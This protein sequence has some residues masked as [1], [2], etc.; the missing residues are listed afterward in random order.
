MITGL[1]ILII[2]DTERSD[3]GVSSS[4]L[5]FVPVVA[6]CNTSI[7]IGTCLTSRALW[8]R[9]HA[10]ADNMKFHKNRP[11]GLY[12]DRIFQ[13]VYSIVLHAQQ[14]IF[15]HQCHLLLYIYLT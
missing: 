15:A 9:H 12:I 2:T 3:I 5:R 4:W 8:G 10:V 11:R 6:G 14:V 13:V 1:L 7:F